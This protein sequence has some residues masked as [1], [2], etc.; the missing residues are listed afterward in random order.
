M[1]RSGFFRGTFIFL[2]RSTFRNFLSVF[3][4][5]TV[6]WFYEV[7]REQS[8]ILCSWIIDASMSFAPYKDWVWILPFIGQRV[9]PHSLC[10]IISNTRMPEVIWSRVSALS[11]VRKFKTNNS[12][13][14]SVLELPD[15]G[16]RIPP[17]KT[18]IS[19]ACSKGFDEFFLQYLGL[20][21]YRECQ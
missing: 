20:G 13:F 10:I 8:S 9:S 12:W 15:W 11:Y 4:P 18:V 17:P 5:W 2:Q 1:I 19:K 3:L 6:I 21:E 14:K 16:C 7:L